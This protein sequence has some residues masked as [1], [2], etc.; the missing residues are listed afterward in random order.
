LSCCLLLWY[1]YKEKEG[2]DDCCHR[3]LSCVW[4]KKMLTLRRLFLF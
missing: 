3:L 2:N 1:D 4:E